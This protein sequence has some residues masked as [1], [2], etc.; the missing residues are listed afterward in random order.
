MIKNLIFDAGGVLV[1]PRRGSW[2]VP[3]GAEALLGG[4]A[5]DF[6]RPEAA[7]AADLWLD[8]SQTVSD[9]RQEL[10]LRRSY[11][12]ALNAAF[13]WGL[14]ADGAAALSED[15]T[16]NPERYG[17]FEDAAPQLERWKGR[18]GLALLSD[19]MPSLLDVLAEKGV[20]PLMD[21]AVIST[22]VGA[23]KPDRRM[24]DAVLA[25]LDARPE[26]CLFVDDKAQNV[27]AARAL[28]LRAVQMAR[29]E[30]PP[31]ALWDGP[32]VHSLDEMNERLEAGDGF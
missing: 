31:Q 32:V 19:A 6:K 13:G 1:F 28:G 21:A 5:A 3:M 23:I 20:L 12:D 30:L 27:S 14:D 10:A 18:Y 4:R 2:I 8:E 26:E 16:F 29:P 15:F 11:I 24:Y 25:G 9:T 17:F 22:H 7:R